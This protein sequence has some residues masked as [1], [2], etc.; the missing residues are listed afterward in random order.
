ME[1]VA[2]RMAFHFVM[3]LVGVLEASI[4]A[5]R[6]QDYYLPIEW[7]LCWRSTFFY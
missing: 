6:E 1:G 2:G 7:K 5:K 3:V 4:A